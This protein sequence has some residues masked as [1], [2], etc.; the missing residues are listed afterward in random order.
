VAISALYGSVTAAETVCYWYNRGEKH[1]VHQKPA[2]GH[3]FCGIPTPQPEIALFPSPDALSVSECN[4][5]L[6]LSDS[7]FL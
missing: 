2:S 1:K 4:A 5:Y 6:F 3:H 7:E